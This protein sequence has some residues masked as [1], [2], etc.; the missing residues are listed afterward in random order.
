MSRCSNEEL[1]CSSR[2][3]VILFFYIREGSLEE[4]IKELK[5]LRKL[6]TEFAKEGA[7]QGA[8]VSAKREADDIRSASM[9]H[10]THLWEARTPTI[11][12]LKVVGPLVRNMSFC[13]LRNYVVPRN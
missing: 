2:F 4:L 1:R 8:N 9:Q 5:E 6:T 7:H 13:S 12:K 11:N 10:I 3:C